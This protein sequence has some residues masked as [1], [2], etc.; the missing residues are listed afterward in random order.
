MFYLTNSV[1]FSNKLQKYIRSVV[2]FWTIIHLGQIFISQLHYKFG[3][4]DETVHKI[5]EVNNMFVCYLAHI[6]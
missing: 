1:S 4:K 5:Y 3:G 2:E 6:S